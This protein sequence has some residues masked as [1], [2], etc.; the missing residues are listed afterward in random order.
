MT[1]FISVQNFFSVFS[2][3]IQNIALKKIYL[4]IFQKVQIFFLLVSIRLF[5]KSQKIINVSSLRQSKSRNRP[6][7]CLFSKTYLD[8]YIFCR[9]QSEFFDQYQKIYQL[10]IFQINL[11]KVYI[12]FLLGPTQNFEKSQKI[13]QW[14]LL[15]TI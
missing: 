14:S 11:E 4:T 5:N 8:E 3:N 1:L 12:L 6:K 13:Y 10:V 15:E 9:N 7:M 2:G